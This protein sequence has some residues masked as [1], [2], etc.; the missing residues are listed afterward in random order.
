MITEWKALC[1]IAIF[2]A[3][4][5]QSVNSQASDCLNNWQKANTAPVCFGARDTQFGSFYLPSGGGLVGIKLVHRYGY[6]SCDVRHP[7]HWSF[8]GCGQHSSLSQE[9]NV[10]I[11]TSDNKII[12]PPGQFMKYNHQAGKWARVPGY[13]SASKEIVLTPFTEPY[14]VLSGQQLRLWYGEDLQGYTEGDNGGRVCCDVY[15]QFHT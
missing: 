8:W 12:L 15:V 2:F 6:V 5:C 7:Q 4:T 1:L 11:T 10:L 3:V 14:A 9:V 13:N